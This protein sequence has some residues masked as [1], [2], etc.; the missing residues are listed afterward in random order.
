MQL[1]GTYGGVVESNQDPEK[2]GRVKV[3]VPHVYGATA[4]GSGGTGTGYIGT[5]D[6]PWAMPSGMPAGGTKASGGFSHI[7]DVGDSVW[8]RFLDGE[9]EK[10]IYEWGMQTTP[11]RDKFKLHS[12]KQAIPGSTKVGPPERAAWTKYGHTFEINA[13]GLLATTS[14]GYQIILTDAS[15]TGSLDGEIKIATAAGNFIQFED[16]TKSAKVFILEDWTYNVGGDWLVYADT[17]TINTVNDIEFIA[18][19]AIKA[20]TIDGFKFTTSTDFILNA[21]G[22]CNLSADTN[23]GLTTLGIMA[24]DFDTLVLGQGASEPFVLGTQFSTWATTLLT[25]LS[26]HVHTSSSPGSPTS[27]PTVPPQITPQVAQLLSQSILGL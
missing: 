22:E 24:F 7:P 19:G 17:A 13:A 10:P 26:T 2:L 8:V 6:L 20:D 18:F 5:N 15:T 23:L 12:Y 3:R 14:Q 9:P 11:Q 4:S 1:L 21:I 27:P 25:W 16:L